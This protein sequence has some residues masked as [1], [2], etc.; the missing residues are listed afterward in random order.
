M[1][2]RHPDVSN[3]TCLDDIVQSLHLFRNQHRNCDFPGN[4]KTY[5]LLDRGVIIEAMAC[6]QR[7]KAQGIKLRV[8]PPT[9]KDVDIVKSQSLQTELDG[10]EDV[11]NDT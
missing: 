6:E 5:C 9:L 8:R 4:E 7:V 3:I 10:V 11:L 2:G 1:A